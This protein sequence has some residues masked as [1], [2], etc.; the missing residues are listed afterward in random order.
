MTNDINLRDILK[1]YIKNVSGVSVVS[2]EDCLSAMYDA[3]SLSV[4]LCNKNAVIKNQEIPFTGVRAGG[5]YIVK[6]IDRESILK[7][8]KLIIK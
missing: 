7:T 6:I 1:P 5:G 4:D 2:I 8:K 3:C